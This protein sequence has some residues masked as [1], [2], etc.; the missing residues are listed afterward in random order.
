MKEI[1]VTQYAKKKK[2]TRQAVLKKIALGKLRAR[3]S[4]NQYLIKIR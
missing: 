2:I 1:T 3:K 4:G